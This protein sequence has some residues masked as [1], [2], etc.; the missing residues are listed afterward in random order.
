[1]TV[2]APFDLVIFDLD[3]TL[4]DS[5]PDIAT[6]LNATLSEVGLSPLPLPVVIGY[7][8]DGAAKLLDRALERAPV[9]DAR[10]PAAVLLQ[11][12][13]TH[14]R[15]H[16]CERTRLYPGITELLDKL[17]AA[18]TLLAVLTNK[19][20]ALARRLVDALG[21]TDRFF[22]IVGD[23]AGFP[24]KPDPTA[25]REII[26]RVGTGPER[27]AVVGDG[28]PDV[29]MAA[30]VPCASVA[31]AWGYLPAERLRAEQPRFLAESV[32]AAARILFGMEAPGAVPASKR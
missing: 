6:A 2:R 32:A 15:D 27:T 5:A 21:I 19:P 26:A 23:G 14:Y 29:R 17:R 1:M 7:V 9:D 12:F 28:L 22:A 18:G 11:R 30:A 4:V 25:A 3:G 13:L 16:I 10:P 24:R 31:A 8:G 20:D